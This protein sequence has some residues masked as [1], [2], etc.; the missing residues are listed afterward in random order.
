MNKSRKEH[1]DA[2][3]KDTPYGMWVLAAAKGRRAE[4]KKIADKIAEAYPFTL[5]NADN[6]LAE[7]IAAEL[8]PGEFQE[9]LEA[10]DAEDEALVDFMI[11]S[12]VF[13]NAN[14]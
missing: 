11:S 7:K 8:K 5:D 10:L 14:K 3:W 1:I 13:G 6:L 9:Y 2:L 12:D 4:A